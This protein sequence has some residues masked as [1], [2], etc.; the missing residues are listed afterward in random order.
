MTRLAHTRPKWPFLKIAFQKHKT[1]ARRHCDKP[2]FFFFFLSV[3]LEKCPQGTALRSS[4]KSLCQ[5]LPSSETLGERILRVRINSALCPPP[6]SPQ[7]ADIKKISKREFKRVSES[8]PQ[9]SHHSSGTLWTGMTLANFFSLSLPPP[10]V[11]SLPGKPGPFAL[12][13]WMTHS[14]L[15]SRVF[16][17]SGCSYIGAPRKIC[18][19]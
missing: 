11:P 7:R 4:K 18:T 6:H 17:P 3:L 2:A 14:S 19:D 12:S 16:H 13:A 1:R 15:Q 5:S 10:V 9:Q 8:S